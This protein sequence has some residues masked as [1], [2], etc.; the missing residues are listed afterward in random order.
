MQSGE[1]KSDKYNSSE[2]SKSS[3]AEENSETDDRTKDEMNTKP[4]GSANALVASLNTA[5]KKVMRMRAMTLNHRYLRRWRTP[6]T[7][8][9]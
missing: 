3:V 1:S 8:G 5:V 9:S 4:K 7:K 6:T 2:E